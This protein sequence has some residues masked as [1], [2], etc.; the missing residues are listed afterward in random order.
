MN[1]N[2]LRKKFIDFFVSKG[3][4]RIE[5]KSLIPENDP[6]VLF[7]TAGMHPLVPYLLGAEHPQGKRLVNFQKCIRTGDIDAVGDFSHLTFFEML[8]NWSLG[9]YF[10]EGAITMSY[11]FL[12]SPQ[13]LGIPHERLGVTVFAGEEGIP[14]DEESAL[15]WRKLGFSDDKISFRPRED[16]WWGP[17]GATGPCGPDSEMFI[18]MGKPPCGP[19]CAP[20]CGCG[21]WL[22]I[23]NDVF[24]QYNKDANGV[25]LPLARKCVDTGMGVERTVTILTG[26]K[27]VYDTEIFKPIISAIEAESNCSYGKDEGQDRSIRIIADHI[28]S[29]TFILGDPKA[30][31]PS[32]VGAGY[33]LRRLIR[34]AVRHGR[35][36]GIEKP[37]LT[38]ISKVVIAE[39]CGPYPE[40]EQ[41]RAAIIEELEKEELRFLET[42]QKGEK[43]FEKLL[44]NLMRSPQKVMSGRL[45]FKLYDTYGFPIE[46][47][48]ELAHENGLSINKDEFE[49]AFAKHQE[50][51]RAGEAVFKGGLADH[52]EITTKYH[53]ATH[54]LQKALQL[55][56]GAHVAQRGSNITAERLRFDFS[57]TAPMT[58]EEIKKAEAIVN[59]QIERDLPVTVEVMSLEA[60][61]AAGAMALFGEKY[62]AQV[63]VYTIG[64]FSK[65]VCGGPHAERTGTLGR[66]KIQK[67]QSSSSGVRR[68][69]AVLEN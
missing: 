36:L 49:A 7:T 26:K 28:R 45:A 68:I 23:W 48:E 67:E 40:L 41:N 31:T 1:A 13:W 2:E 4:A 69:R 19:D 60:A 22:E 30:V 55:V 6:T 33:V 56:L 12:T 46:L 63:K 43:E 5:G 16:N 8:G 34:R 25:Y 54:L 3:H 21:K 18:D 27:S 14:R 32:N 51:S 9:D 15:I 39:F 10:K 58:Q 65:E 66:F 17:A 62:E 11:E 35:K 50:T 20:G 53:T 61:K 29:S 47:T 44:P 64:D 38:A 52:S 24:M 37:F 57:H 59:E 42:L